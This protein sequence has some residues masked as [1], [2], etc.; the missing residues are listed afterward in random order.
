MDTTDIPNENRGGDLYTASVR[1]NNFFAYLEQMDLFSLLPDVLDKRVDHVQDSVYLILVNT[2]G[3]VG[4]VILLILSG[5]C[6]RSGPRLPENGRLAWGILLTYYIVS[7]LSG[8]FINSFPN[9]QL[10]FIVLGRSRS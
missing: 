8:S 3:L 7:G 1:W 5:I 4:F 10:F 2:F 6:M 9:N